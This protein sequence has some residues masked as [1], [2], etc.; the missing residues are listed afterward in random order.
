MTPSRA[1]RDVVPIASL[2][3]T[4]GTEG[5]GVLPRRDDISRS[6]CG[7]SA[8]V[9]RG[10]VSPLPAMRGRALPAYRPAAVLSHPT[11][12]NERQGSD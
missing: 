9:G 4:L 8:V 1:P 2:L 10:T 3:E 7:P 11:A 6:S 12:G 5:G